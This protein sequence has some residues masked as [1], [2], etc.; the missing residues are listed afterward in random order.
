MTS[1][2]GGGYRR[3]SNPNS[4]G[5]RQPRRRSSLLSA[6]MTSR[7]LDA[8]ADMVTISDQPGLAFY[9][10]YAH[11]ADVADHLAS[12]SKGKNNDNDTPYRLT[13][14]AAAALTAHELLLDLLYRSDLDSVGSGRRTTTTGSDGIGLGLL[15]S[16]VV[17][18]LA[19]LLRLAAGLA[20]EYEQ[21]HGHET[22]ESSAPSTSP[23][24][25][26]VASELE[27]LSFEF[28]CNRTGR[29]QE[30][31]QDQSP[32]LRASR[33]TE[34]ADAASL[35]LLST[36]TRTA[37]RSSV[38][39]LDDAYVLRS[40]GVGLDDDVR[41][42]VEALRTTTLGL[43]SATCTNMEGAS[44]SSHMYC[45]LACA[46]PALLRRTHSGG[47]SPHGPEDLLFQT[48][49][50][51]LEILFWY[52]ENILLPQFPIQ[53]DQDHDRNSGALILLCAV[54][55]VGTK[56]MGL[57][58]L[59]L[60]ADFHPLRVA[61]HGSS[62]FYSQ[63][64]HRIRAWFAKA[65]RAAAAGADLDRVHPC[66]ELYVEE[67]LALQ[68][69]DRASAAFRTLAFRHYVLAQKVVGSNSIGSAGK[70]FEQMQAS[71]L[72]HPHGE[73]NAAKHRMH[74]YTSFKYSNFVGLGTQAVVDDAKTTAMGSSLNSLDDIGFQD[75]SYDDGDSDLRSPSEA[76]LLE[77]GRSIAEMD[78]DSF[79]DLFDTDNCRIEQPTATLPYL[80]PKIR[81][82]LLNLQKRHPVIHSCRIQARTGTGIIVALDADLFEGTSVQYQLEGECAMNRDGT[83]II[84]LLLTGNPNLNEALCGYD[85]QRI[86][87]WSDRKDWSKG[88]MDK[89]NC[90][91]L[92]GHF[93]RPMAPA[94]ILAYELNKSRG[95]SVSDG[96]TIVARSFVFGALPDLHLVQ[97]ALD[98]CASGHPLLTACTKHTEEGYYFVSNDKKSPH[99]QLQII[100]N[101]TS[102]LDC[103]PLLNEQFD[104]ESG[105]MLRV[106][107]CV[108]GPPSK[109]SF[110]FVTVMFHGVCDAISCRDLHRQMIHR[111]ALVSDNASSPRTLKILTE[112]VRPSA[113]PPATMHHAQK[114]LAKRSSA[115][116]DPEPLPEPV[117]IHTR[118]ISL[119]QNKPL[120]KSM[121]ITE[122]F[123]AD[124][125]K[126]LLAVCK[127][128]GTTMHAVLGA[129]S[130]LSADCGDSTRRVL[131][132]AV[133][134][135]RRLDMPEDVMVYSVGGFDGSAAF[136][137]NLEN[138]G[139]YKDGALDIWKLSHSIRE[140]IV[141]TV[142]SGRLLSTYLSSVEG[143]VDAYKAGFLDGGC[144]GT[145]FLSNVGNESY[146]KEIGSFRW[147]EFDYVYG[148]FLPG[149]P[150]YHITCSTFDGCL[151]LNFQYVSPTIADSDA[152]AFARSTISLLK[153]EI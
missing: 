148:Q 39:L 98:Q 135:R 115:A 89:P 108:F 63:A 64:F 107:I 31:D 13:T 33:L 151:T 57:L 43:P 133:D 66:P 40:A 144:F 50:V 14:L 110:E 10:S 19:T 99:I 113:I 46:I 25:G 37:L 150:H 26:G 67:T 21:E 36:S 111:L 5:G 126:A 45:R 17:A 136:E 76:I 61:V 53:E 131:T 78:M 22:V 149:G 4:G 152:H 86:F 12:I 125:T 117:P 132:S 142:D 101:S 124:E 68:R 134:L 118:V 145:V 38:A 88:A 60:L 92:K 93:C 120:P 62:G 128:N 48:P 35:N 42:A 84:R 23:P 6:T 95:K 75:G 77:L 24:S 129:A 41:D 32:E 112:K 56:A 15:V 9:T 116:K 137:Y 121:F 73:S 34:L 90:Q 127:K 49:H 28:P 141:D 109:P 18:S 147:T 83:K 97:E 16:D 7:T 79:L 114:I 138:Y 143:L 122:R 27:S 106:I 20:E 1:S 81:A 91:S 96:L 139:N 87:A 105:D 103:G 30:Q 44:S 47:S 100:E 72:R 51:I 130:L 94:E 58:D 69:L 123:S 2:E 85:D 8:V 70:T 55:D 146:E 3:S 74:E 82:Y 11:V 52:A 65:Y 80:G 153:K 104:C 54:L 119:D 71:F 59:M 29:L 102:R 140:D